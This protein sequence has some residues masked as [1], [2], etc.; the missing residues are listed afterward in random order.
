LVHHGGIGTTAQA[1]A[2]GVP[3][4]VV[5]SAHDQPDNAVR[6][7]R[8]GIGGFLLPSAYTPGHVAERLRG[9]LSA[10]VRENCQRRAEDLAGSRSLEKT[11]QSIEEL[12][13]IHISGAP[14]G[15]GS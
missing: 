10:K 1:I 15:G 8:L 13:L 6:I 5:P 9:L 7:R 12:A 11:A 2:A 3:Q 14:T 4:L